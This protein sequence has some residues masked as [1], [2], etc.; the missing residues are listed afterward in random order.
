MFKAQ[1]EISSSQHEKGP[2]GPESQVEI[3]K[4]FYFV[5]IVN[6]LESVFIQKIFDPN[7]TV[8]INIKHLDKTV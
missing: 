4:T 8:L 1:A 3:L 6:K 5:S 7:L 2:L